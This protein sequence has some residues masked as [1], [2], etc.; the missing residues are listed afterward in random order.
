MAA[1]FRIL[2]N[3]RGEVSDSFNVPV[4][5]KNNEHYDFVCL[6]PRTNTGSV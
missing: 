5:D 6:S 2:R 1:D 4:R 3:P